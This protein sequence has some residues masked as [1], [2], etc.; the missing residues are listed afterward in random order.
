MN[1]RSFLKFIPAGVIGA[2]QA[3]E[4]LALGTADALGSGLGAQ[5]AGAFYDAVETKGPSSI[6]GDGSW[7]RESLAR[8]VDP[9]WLAEMRRNTHVDCIDPDLASMQSIS[10]SVKMQM[11]R[12][13]NVERQVSG[14][15]TRL[16]RMLADAGILS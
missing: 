13:R 9:E 4:K 15:R 5:Y 14:E 10:L 7:I 1:R 3:A 12:D 16:E 6:Y 2:K 11:Q 8:L